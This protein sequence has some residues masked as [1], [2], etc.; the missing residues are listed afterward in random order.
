VTAR[1]VAILS[2]N[3][4]FLPEIGEKQVDDRCRDVS[5]AGVGEPSAAGA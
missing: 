4:A 5:T 2:G 1:A 3:V